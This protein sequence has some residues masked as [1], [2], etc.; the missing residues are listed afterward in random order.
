[1]AIGPP[2]LVVLRAVGLGDLLTAIPALRALAEAFPAH[3]RILAAP[4]QLRPLAMLSGAVDEVVDSAPLEPLSASLHGA[5]VAVNLHGRGPDS[6][7]VLLDARPRRL[8]AFAHD[9]IA[10]SRGG[11]KWRPDEHEVH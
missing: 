6:H 5:D 3:R 11:P 4:Q 1:M 7:H 9:A 8:L 2:K 10:T